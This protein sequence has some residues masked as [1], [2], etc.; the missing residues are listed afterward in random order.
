[1]VP[2][3]AAV[4][5]GGGI[6]GWV[7]LVGLVVLAIVLWKGFSRSRATPAGN[8]AT[9][10]GPQGAYPYA[11][12]N[13]NPAG[14]AYGPGAA[15]YGPGMQGGPMQQGARPGGGMLG[16][17]LAVAGGIAGGMLLDQMLHRGGSGGGEGSGIGNLGGVDP[18]NSG[19]GAFGIDAAAQELES[20][21]IDFGNGG[22][23]W[24]SGGGSSDSGGGDSGGGGWD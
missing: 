16:T 21:P 11:A 12:N 22:N 23:D 19:S 1:M 8:M 9:A 10:G 13:V 14:A 3:A 18:G 4:G 20:R 5:S 24:D 6:P 17:G 7:W 15:G 2:A